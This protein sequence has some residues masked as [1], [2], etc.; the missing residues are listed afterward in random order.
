MKTNMSLEEFTDN[1]SETPDGYCFVIFPWCRWVTSLLSY[2]GIQL[3]DL[4]TAKHSVN[5]NTAVVSEQRKAM[6][7]GGGTP[8]GG[9]KP[10]GL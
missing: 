1:W 8:K 6:N 10:A 7:T 9:E 3:P 5:S 2:F 4:I